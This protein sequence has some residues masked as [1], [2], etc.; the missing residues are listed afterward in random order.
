MRVIKILL[1]LILLSSTACESFPESTRELWMRSGYT[2]SSKP[3]QSVVFDRK[4]QRQEK[5]YLGK[6]ILP[7]GDV[8]EKGSILIQMD[9]IN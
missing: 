3:Q 6:R 5:V 9:K 2:D 1:S 4:I 7:N 8:F